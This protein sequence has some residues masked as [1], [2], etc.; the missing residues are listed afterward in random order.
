MKKRK[1]A[2]SIMEAKFRKYLETSFI[3]VLSLILIMELIP[4]SKRTFNE[5]SVKLEKTYDWGLGYKEQGQQPTGNTDREFLK[6]YDSYYVGSPD[7]KVI[8]L[9]FDAGYENG[10]TEK[11]LDVMKKHQVPSA[12]F[13][14][15]H[16]IRDNPELVKRMEQ[17]GHQVC[18]HTTR[19]PNMAKI[20]DIGAFKTELEGVEQLYKEV[21]GKE[22]HKF[23]RPPQGKFTEDNLKMAKELSY[24]T[25]FWSLA[26]VD[27][28]E[29]QQPEPA[30]AIKKLS[31]RIHPGAIVLLHSNSKTNADILEELIVKWK[32][33]GYRFETLY[34]LTGEMDS[35]LG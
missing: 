8:Y 31:S 3:V 32:D 16:Y 5:V 23:Y 21:T 29:D 10:N 24:S 2:M 20:S 27:W 14:V 4:L 6:K 1:G 9:T 28:K 25:I 22:M 11:L 15:S 30:Y 35:P 34:H 13:L 7:E 18:N 12:F 26:Y 19:H 17:E 33:E